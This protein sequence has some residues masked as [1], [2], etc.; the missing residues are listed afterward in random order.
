MAQPEITPIS[1]EQYALVLCAKDEGA[2]LEVA[3][4]LAAVRP[5]AFSHLVLLAPMG[6]WDAEDPVADAFGTTMTEQRALLTADPAATA[7]AALA[8]NEAP[9]DMLTVES[10]AAEAGEEIPAQAETVSGEA[11]ASGT[12]RRRGGRRG[13]NGRDRERVPASDAAVDSAP[14]ADTV[15][16][17]EG[18]EVAETTVAEASDDKP[19]RGAR[20]GRGKERVQQAAEGVTEQQPLEAPPVLADAAQEPAPES[21]PGRGGRR[22]RKAVAADS[23]P[24][25]K[26]V[27]DAAVD[28]AKP[29]KAKRT[30]R[31]RKPKAADTAEG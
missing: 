3:L 1:I 22:P 9:V 24:E 12:Q 29:A 23:A 17:A 21:K 14:L 27:A 20:R 19:R 2:P 18:L 6:L 30:A 16:P 7:R 10:V 8:D 25:T 4:E 5:E 15:V 26:P 13:R 31:P 28:E 11:E